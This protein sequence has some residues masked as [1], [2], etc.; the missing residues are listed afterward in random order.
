MSTPNRFFRQKAVQQELQL[1]KNANLDWTQT[2]SA[3]NAKKWITRYRRN[4]DI[5]AQELFEW[6]L[7]P[8]QLFKLHM[9]GVA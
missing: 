9:M 1:A 3:K 7:Y 4:W 2:D 6:K 5:L 8:V